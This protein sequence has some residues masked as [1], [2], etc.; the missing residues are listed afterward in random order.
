MLVLSRFVGQ[1]IMIG[2]NITITIVEIRSNK[3]RI[4]IDAPP[5]IPVNRLEVYEEK[6]ANGELDSGTDPGS[7]GN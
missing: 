4:S 1:T 5:N 7:S 6:K 2:D 3:V